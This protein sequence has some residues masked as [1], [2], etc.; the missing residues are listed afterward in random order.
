MPAIPDGPAA[1]QPSPATGPKPAPSIDRHSDIGSIKF[2]LNGGQDGFMEDWHF[3]G[4]LNQSAPSPASKDSVP[5]SVS[6]SAPNSVNFPVD[7]NFSQANDYPRAFHSFFESPFDAFHQQWQGAAAGVPNVPTADGLWVYN[8]A[9]P[10]SVDYTAYAEPQTPNV[11]ALLDALLITLAKLG[12]HLRKQQELTAD[13]QF[14]LTPARVRRFAAMYG[15]IWHPN[16]P[17]IHMASFNIETATLPL[18]ASVVSM[19][20]MYS[21][22]PRELSAVKSILDLVEIFVFESELFSHHAEIRRTMLTPDQTA[23]GLPNDWLNFQNFQAAYLNVVV[24]HWAGNKIAR[25]RSMETRFSQVVRVARSLGLPKARHL[26]ED[27]LH[28]DLWIQ[29]ECQIRTMNIIHSIDCAFLFFHNFPCRMSFAEMECDLPC[30]ELLFSSPTPFAEPGFQ[31]VRGLTLRQG[32]ESLFK[33]SPS[34][35]PGEH[36]RVLD[37][38]LLIHGLDE[39]DAVIARILVAL[40]Q[41]REL[42]NATCNAT[43]RDAWTITGFFKAS[44]KY[45]LVAH[46]VASKHQQVEGGWLLEPKCEQKLERLQTLAG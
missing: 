3:P 29:R 43:T 6:P 2:L 40:K 26:P 30:D 7:P 41:W 37:M 8:N 5:P 44:Y 4:R 45:W 10:E 13:L 31:L 9:S 46:L 11:A 36:F 15:K 14:L 20:A 23:S 27:R 21:G 19:G 38:F 42:W 35:K 32:F 24:Q 28:Q 12:P 1:V 25:D 18:L 22:D 39:P 17:I 33:T 34:L 16:C